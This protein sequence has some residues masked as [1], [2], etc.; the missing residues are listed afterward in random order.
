[1]KFAAECCLATANGATNPGYT[2]KAGWWQHVL[3]LKLPRCDSWTNGIATTDARQ[4][5]EQ[6]EVAGKAGL[7][8]RR[9]ND[10]QVYRASLGQLLISMGCGKR[11][12]GCEE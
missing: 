12:S 6:T 9:K 11:A 1:M 4:G 10:V 5:C 7:Y 2:L 8:R 3:A